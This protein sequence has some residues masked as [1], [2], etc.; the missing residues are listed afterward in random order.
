MAEG[1]HAQ[2]QALSER[3]E[4]GDL[5]ALRDHL[6][7]EYFT[8]EPTAGEA[9]ANDRIADLALGFQAGLP[10]LAATISDISVQGDRAS[11]TL[12]VTGSHTAA[13]WGVPP[14]GEAIEWTTPMTVR[15]VDG[16]VAVRID[17]TTT[18]QRVG[19]LRQLRLV[20]PADEM[21]LPAHHPHD[22]PDFLLKLVLTGQAGDKPCSHLD[23][24][25]VTSPT[26]SVCE[27][28]EA[29]GDVWPA[30]RMCLICGFVGCCDTAKNRHMAAHYQETGHPIIR[31]INRGERWVW[32]Y[33]DDAFFEG[34][35]LDR[36]TG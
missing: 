30:L 17:E 3:L 33:E 16:R 10:D 11:A 27:Q 31:S 24:I 36:F 6:A 8:H 29:T 9:G 2:L 25:E 20:N 14:S 34:T 15:A 18:P 1:L 32:C 21:D 35:V 22:A 5:E 26:T 13:L 19:L 4:A 28:C 23:Q 12:T 7:R